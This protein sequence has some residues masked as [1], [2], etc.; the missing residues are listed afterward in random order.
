M[1]RITPTERQVVD[2]LLGAAQGSYQSVEAFVQQIVDVL[3]LEHKDAPFDAVFE[4]SGVD[5]LLE[6][7][8]IEVR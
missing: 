4:P 7:T 1:D 3:D 6:R 8:E 5:E 2:E